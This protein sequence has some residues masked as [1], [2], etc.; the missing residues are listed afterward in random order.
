MAE[1]G[2][3]KET[4]DFESTVGRDVAV[5]GPA[6][7][8]IEARDG[9]SFA[10]GVSERNEG[11]KAEEVGEGPDNDRVDVDKD[12]ID[13]GRFGYA[14]WPCTEPGRTCNDIAVRISFCNPL[15]R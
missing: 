10:L 5:P 13:T 14:R 3:V 7:A 11:L 6:N 1:H 9:P 8:A 12:A 15:R 2:H 4:R